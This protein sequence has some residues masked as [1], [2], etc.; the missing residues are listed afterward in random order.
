M[1]HVFSISAIYLEI[2]KY[3]L[4]SRHSSFIL[5]SRQTKG[6]TMTATQI[7]TDTL[8]IAIFGASGQV[9]QRLVAEGTRRGHRI[10]AIARSTPKPGIHPE[11]VDHL[12]R[13]VLSASD[14]DA[15]IAEHDIVLSALRPPA[16]LESRMVEMTDRIIDASNRSGTRFMIV[17]G[18]APLI[19]PDAPEHTVLTKPNFLP[20]SSVAIAHAS[21][22][23]F[24]AAFPKLGSLGTYFCPPA[25][26]VPGERTGTY[27]THHDTLVVDSDGQSQISMEDYAVAMFDEIEAP[28]HTGR[29]FTA[30]Y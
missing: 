10:T 9:G 13:D 30:A 23:Q 2:K 17:G 6:A 15:I 14:L 20:E 8:S 27:R 26:L 7:S 24:E 12:S 25:M 11:G 29:H 18:A 19:T 16:G 3:I 4:T 28:K 1:V 21:Q 22:T 5:I